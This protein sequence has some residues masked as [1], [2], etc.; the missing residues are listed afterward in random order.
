RRRRL[1]RLRFIHQSFSHDC[2]SISSVGLTLALIGNV[3]TKVSDRV[4]MICQCFSAIGDE[5]PAVCEP[6]ALIRLRGRLQLFGGDDPI[7]SRGSESCPNGDAFG[8]LLCSCQLRFRP[9][10]TCFG[11]LIAACTSSRSSA[12]SGW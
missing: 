10:N 5:V 6:C 9:L 7:V 4:P 2:G 3:I 12:S 1:A 11:S 8:G